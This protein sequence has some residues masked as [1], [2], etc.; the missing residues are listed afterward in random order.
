MSFPTRLEIRGDLPAHLDARVPSNEPAFLLQCLGLDPTTLE[1]HSFLCHP[2][3]DPL[4]VCISFEF[5]SYL[6]E[7]IGWDQYVKMGVAIFDT[8]ILTRPPITPDNGLLSTHLFSA[9]PVVYE[10]QAESDDLRC[11]AHA[12]LASDLSSLLPKTREIVL[13]GQEA[14]MAKLRHL[15]FDWSAY[16]IAGVVRIET[17]AIEMNMPESHR[18]L[19]CLLNSLDC[20]PRAGLNHAGTDAQVALSVALLLATRLFRSTHRS[21]AYGAV[22]EGM[23]TLLEDVGYCEEEEEVR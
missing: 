6:S 3:Q 15:C 4:L 20:A 17:L 12:S 5:V 18:S 21:S 2:L 8:R 11:L 13:V 23:L 10:R 9:G 7:N 19:A 16:D 22:T 1:S 14:N